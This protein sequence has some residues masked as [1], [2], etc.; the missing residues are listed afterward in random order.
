MGLPKF[1]SKP[2]V[3]RTV[4]GEDGDIT[5]QFFH[6]GPVS[7]ICFRHIIAPLAKAWNGLASVPNATLEQEQ[8]DTTDAVGQRQVVVKSKPASLD[9]LDWAHRTRQDSILKLIENLL[10]EGTLK[11]VFKV[12][13]ISARHHCPNEQARD[14]FVDLLMEA[15]IAEVV[16]PVISGTMEANG[17]NFGPF[18]QAL[19]AMLQAQ[20]EK[21]LAGLSPEEQE[22]AAQDSGK[23]T[24]SGDSSSDSSPDSSERAGPSSTSQPSLFRK[25]TPSADPSTS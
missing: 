2:K 3:E 6:L 20:T 13:A 14:E 5:I 4:P 10:D 17:V 1:K 24:D 23:T 11:E 9:T 16:M 8:S 18:I 12:C 19:K 25:S 7:M 15:D 21:V 22:T